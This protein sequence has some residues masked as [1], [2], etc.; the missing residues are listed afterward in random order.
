MSSIGEKERKLREYKQ[1]QQDVVEART[2][3]GN[4]YIRNFSK[5]L[6]D[7]IEKTFQEFGRTKSRYYPTECSHNNVLGDGWQVELT[8]YDVCMLR[9][10]IWHEPMIGSTWV[11]FV[12]QLPNFQ[13]LFNLSADLFLNKS[14]TLT[15]LSKIKGYTEDQDKYV[16]KPTTHEFYKAL[17]DSD[18]TKCGR[19]DFEGNVKETTLHFLCC[20]EELNWCM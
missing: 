4:V 15:Y 14:L 9:V 3:V 6:G 16:I 18:T 1:A 12:E 17:P 2:E 10:T 19:S 20:V 5:P 13:D 11:D 7:C 8:C